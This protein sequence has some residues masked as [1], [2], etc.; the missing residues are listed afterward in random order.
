MK[1]EK[2]Y[3]F[4]ISIIKSL[5]KFNQVIIIMKE[6]T[7]VIRDPKTFCCNFD[8]S[9]DVDENLKHEIDF[10]IKSN[11]SLAKNKKKKRLNNYC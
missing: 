11:E 8:W 9:K 5:K 10:I 7:T 3:I 6:N 2:Y 1:S 4:C